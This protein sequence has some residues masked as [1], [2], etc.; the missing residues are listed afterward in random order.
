MSAA[1]YPTLY[2]LSTERGRELDR[3]SI[4]DWVGGYVPGGRSSKLGQL[5]EVAYN[6]EYG[7]EPEDQSSLN[8][9]YLLGYAG[10]GQLRLF[11]KSNE[12]YHV[13][14]GNDQ[15]IDALADALAGQITNGA[16]ARI[17]RSGDGTYTLR[18]AGRVSGGAPPTGSCSRS[19]SRSCAGSTFR[20]PVS[21]PRKVTAIREQGMGTNSKLNVQ[22]TGRHWSAIGCNGDTYADT[23]LPGDA[24]T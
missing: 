20:R 12:K 7:A 10:Q 22:F 17:G 11:G 5:L 3:M 2:N 9:L 15:I 13:R 14:G 23:R 21:R 4:A 6:I 24:G 16:L 18:F 1:S 8:M 19:R